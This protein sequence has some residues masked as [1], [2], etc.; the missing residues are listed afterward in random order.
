MARGGFRKG[1]T[2]N[3]AQ[4]RV[5]AARY[6]YNVGKPQYRSDTLA[7]SRPRLSSAPSGAPSEAS[8]RTMAAEYA[9]PQLSRAINELLATTHWLTA[10]PG[11]FA[12]SAV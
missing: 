10:A 4:L 5:L 9:L 11:L 2:M 7:K 1:T 8:A 6:S 3:S 12:P